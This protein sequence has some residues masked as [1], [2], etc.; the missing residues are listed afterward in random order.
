MELI[1]LFFLGGGGYH[2]RD[3]RTV[4]RCVCV[5]VGVGMGYG[6]GC[7]WVSEV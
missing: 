4:D 3:T 5:C 6:G 1:F 2:L 7:V